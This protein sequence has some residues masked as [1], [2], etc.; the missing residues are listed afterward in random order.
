MLFSVCSGGTGTLEAELPAGGVEAFCPRGASKGPTRMRQGR[1]EWEEV[2]WNQAER[3]PQSAW[4]SP[5]EV[6]LVPVGLGTSTCPSLPPPISRPWTAYSPLF[7]PHFMVLFHTP[8][9]R[10]PSRCPL[11][12]ES[13]SQCFPSV[14]LTSV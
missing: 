11:P 3:G 9:C 4:G 14:G 12:L 13:S 5:V 2:G 6:A 7:A 1:P 8:I 10:T